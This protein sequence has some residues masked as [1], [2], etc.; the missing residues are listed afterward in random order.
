MDRADEAGAFVW[1][2]R[3]DHTTTDATL[4]AFEAETRRHGGTV[5]VCVQANLR[6][7]RADLERLTDLPGKVRL[8]KRAYDEP[9]EIAYTDHER[10]N[11]PYRDHP[12]YLFREF[13]GG[14]AVGS[15]DPEMIEHARGL[16]DEYGTG[17]EIQMLMGIRD[18]AQF[19]L[20]REFDLYQYVPYGSRWSSYFH[21][22]V[23]ERKE[24]LAFAVRA[25]VS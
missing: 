7:T 3:E 23:A 15:H 19:E 20:A 14:I 9:D 13:D 1:I 6:R 12:G 24:N 25:I 11:E 16:H 21:R 2:D 17:F 5:G 10:V 18:D 4:D 22:R 8:V